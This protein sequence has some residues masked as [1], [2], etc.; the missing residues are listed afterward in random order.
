MSNAASTCLVFDVRVHVLAFRAPTWTM[1]G[2][3]ARKDRLVTVAMSARAEAQSAYQ[4][5]KQG[6]EDLE[7][8][9]RE[10]QV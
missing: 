9:F 6:T 7:R 3:I 5:M 10:T 8:R 4:Q 1:Q 2:D